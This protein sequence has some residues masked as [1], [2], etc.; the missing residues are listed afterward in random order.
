[1]LSLQ[2]V[3]KSLEN[4]PLN[5]STSTFVEMLRRTV[6]ENRNV[7]VKS[8]INIK[9]TKSMDNLQIFNN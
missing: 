6:R 7:D 2:Q 8:R 4:R 1:M 5:G 3:T 9:R